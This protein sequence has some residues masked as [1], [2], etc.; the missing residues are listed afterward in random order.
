[1]TH[2]K[3]ALKLEGLKNQVRDT[4]DG[5]A[6][7]LLNNDNVDQREQKIEELQKLLVWQVG[8]HY[9]NDWDTPEFKKAL[10]KVMSGMYPS[11]SITLPE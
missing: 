10:D 11:G 1:M 2:V 3:T 5:L 6:Q 4:Y 8:L 7:E 9:I